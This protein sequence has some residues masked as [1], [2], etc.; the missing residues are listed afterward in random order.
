MTAR[1]GCNFLYGR[2][3]ETALHDDLVGDEVAAEERA[4]LARVIGETDAWLD[5]TEDVLAAGGPSEARTLRLVESGADVIG[6]PAVGG[7]V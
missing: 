5:G 7:D 6:F 3:L 4:R 2:L 1:L